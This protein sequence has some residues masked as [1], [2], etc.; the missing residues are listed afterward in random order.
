MEALIVQGVPQR[1]AHEAIGHLVAECERRGCRRL[2]D[3]PDSVFTEAHPGLGPGV[4]EVL[5]VANAIKAFRSY[6]STAPAE[7]AKQL[8]LWKKRLSDP[9]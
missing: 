3:L 9:S 2:A 1:T 4:K 5:G 7:V 6:G 8:E